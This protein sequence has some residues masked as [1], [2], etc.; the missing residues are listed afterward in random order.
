VRA[1]KVFDLPL[2]PSTPGHDGPNGPLAPEVAEEL[3]A[4]TP[5][6]HG[7][8]EVDAFDHPRFDEAGRAMGR[9]NR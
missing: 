7:A 1:A 5:T 3:P 4:D 6:I 8:G 2:V 9:P